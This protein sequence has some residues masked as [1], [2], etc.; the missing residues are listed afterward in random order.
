MV[1]FLS[2]PDHFLRCVFHS[3]GDGEIESGFAQNFLAQFHV[4][5]FQA[6]HHR[7]LDAEAASR[8]HYATGHDVAAH[9][10]A[11]NV[12]QDGAHVRVAEDNLKAAAHL[13]LACASAHI[14][15]VGRTPA[16]ILDD[17]H[18]VDDEPRA[19]P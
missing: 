10:A 12:D 14:E 7:N 6:H 19:V 13:L 1:Q 5:T 9:D 16:R 3:L 11:E 15:E 18:Q 17:V 8:G 2:Q 4:R